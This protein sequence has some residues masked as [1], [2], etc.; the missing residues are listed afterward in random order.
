MAKHTHEDAQ[1]TRKAIL[2]SAMRLFSRRG[3]ERTSLS[4]IAKYA[5]VTRGA[6]YWHF[7][8]KKDLLFELCNQVD[9][10]LLRV[11]DLA[12]FASPSED[13]PL[14]KL[15]H[16]MKEHANEKSVQFF[17]SSFFT[18]LTGIMRGSL[19]D[20]ALIQ[21]LSELVDMRRRVFS[22]V[23]KNCIRKGQLPT[24]LDIQA[25]AD[26]I[27]LFNTGYINLLSVDFS[28]VVIKNFPTYVDAYIN[29]LSFITIDATQN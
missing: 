29:S 10:D 11:E 18:M 7:D 16:W 28:D 19:E 22:D 8:D 6:I 15:R 24:N 1:L 26:S 20:E 5:G 2:D 21:R 23:L 3:F 9:K 17:R 13:K 14:D 12:G 27:I 25:A 4:D